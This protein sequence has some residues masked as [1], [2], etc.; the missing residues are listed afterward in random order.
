MLCYTIMRYWILIT[1]GLVFHFG[2][3][4]HQ[5]LRSNDQLWSQGLK[6]NF[7]LIYDKFNHSFYIDF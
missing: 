7:S 2:S 6:K 3:V 4:L 5:K 1:A